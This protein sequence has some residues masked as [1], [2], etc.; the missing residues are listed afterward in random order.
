MELGD[1]VVVTKS[2]HPFK[3]LWGTIIGRRGFYAPNDPILL[4]YI[5]SRSR[6]FLIPQSM[7][8]L[9]KDASDEELNRWLM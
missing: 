4:V 5:K 2:G 3:G 6:S 1:L 9:K 8:E 7:L